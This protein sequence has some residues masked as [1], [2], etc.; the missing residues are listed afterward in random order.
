MVCA[1][2]SL[3]TA[4][5]FFFSSLWITESGAI[6]TRPGNTCSVLFSVATSALAIQLTVAV[7]LLAFAPFIVAVGQ[8][9]KLMPDRWIGVP[10]TMERKAGLTVV[11]AW[12][13]GHDERT[14]RIPCTR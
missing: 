1:L 13:L 12:G 14:E 2:F 5:A 8:E 3:A 9:R 10:V 7:L 6:Q 4:A 11:P